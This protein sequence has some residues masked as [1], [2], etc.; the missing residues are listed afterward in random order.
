MRH[1]RILAA[2]W[3]AFA[4]ALFLMLALAIGSGIVGTLSFD[5]PA[6]AQRALD[7]P[8]DTLGTGGKSDDLR[9]IRQ[10]VQGNVSIPNKQA[11]VLIQSEGENFRAARNGPLSTFGA[12]VL[13]GIIAVL[14]LFFAL[15]GRIKLQSGWSG[16]VVERFT[17][18]ERFT[19]W[20]TAVSFIVLALSGLNMLY[21]RYVLRPIIGATAFSWLTWIGKLAHNYLAFAFMIGIVLMFVL[22]LRENIPNRYDWQWIKRA[23]GFFS[24]HDHPPAKKFN[25]GQ[26]LVF[27]LVILGGASASL[28]GLALLFPFT[29]AWFSH[30]FAF[31]NIFGLGLP[32]DL[33]PLQDTQLSQIWHAIIGLLMIALIIGHIYIGTIGMEGAFDAMGTGKVDRNWAEEHHQLWV[34]EM[35]QRSP[36]RGDDDCAPAAN[37]WCDSS[38]RPRCCSRPHAS[39]S[40]ARRSR[41]RLTKCPPTS[42]NATM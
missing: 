35:E 33:T 28:S 18:I 37:R 24:K 39:V 23:G 38:Q 34:A 29:L 15:R 40:P 31:L 32:T 21:G 8:A 17:D 2:G 36:A 1:G 12:W 7:P 9:Q 14:A 30:T 42:P 22:W 11:G 5:A 16:L 26:K 41:S 3:S 27:W 19:H 13:F 10:G 4:L 6:L 20:L 25:A